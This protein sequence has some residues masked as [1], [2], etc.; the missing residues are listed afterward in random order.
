MTTC[1]RCGC[2][3][4]TSEP[5]DSNCTQCVCHKK[6]CADGQHVSALVV[7][8]GHLWRHCIYCGALTEP[9]AE[10][11]AAYRQL[12]EVSLGADLKGE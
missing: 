5:M 1:A 8:D 12:V 11:S 6:P 7:H 4:T 3:T 2:P 9:P 10:V